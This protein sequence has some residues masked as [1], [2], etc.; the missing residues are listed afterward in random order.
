MQHASG[1]LITFFVRFSRVTAE[2][3]FLSVWVKP[4]PGIIFTFFHTQLLQLF[5]HKQLHFN[6]LMLGLGVDHN[7][8]L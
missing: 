7:M 1:R 5:F 6:L 2:F 8:Q 4:L 3:L